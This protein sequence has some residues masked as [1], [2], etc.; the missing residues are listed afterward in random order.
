MKKIL[1]IFL[2]IFLSLSSLSASRDSLR[3]LLEYTEYEGSI[4]S[5]D[6]EF[7]LSSDYISQFFN[8]ILYTP[9]AL[10]VEHLDVYA[11]LR[12]MTDYDISSMLSILV[13]GD[14]ILRSNA[15]INII[16]FD[17][18]DSYIKYTLD[19]ALE[20]K[21]K[22]KK[23]TYSVSY[24]DRYTCLIGDD[25]YDVISWGKDDEFYLEYRNYDLRMIY[26]VYGENLTPNLI[27]NIETVIYGVEVN[28][29]RI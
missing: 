14:D 17:T 5:H 4:I 11:R 1:V 19:S 29:Q 26:L 2:I 7:I 3:E 16:R 24:S 27:N 10:W 20:L 28:P 25:V 12:R 13:Y 21:E 18:R 8:Y 23:P 15:L 22:E 6:I 9:D